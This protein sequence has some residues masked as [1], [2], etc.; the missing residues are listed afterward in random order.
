MK[1]F[2]I[3]PMLMLMCS[4]CLADQAAWISK[5]KADAAV[6]IL[7]KAGTVRHYCEPCGDEGYRTEKVL[8]VRSG[9]VDYNDADYYEVLI[10]ETPVD[11]AYVYVRQKGQ[12]TNLA[13]ILEIGVSGVSRVMPADVKEQPQEDMQGS[14]IKDF[15]IV[16]DEDK[17]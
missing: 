8:K 6:K 4:I 7:S 12:W 2:I 10:N 16:D 5:V 15:E 11:I 3:L 1:K 17:K 9:W 14:M 13:M